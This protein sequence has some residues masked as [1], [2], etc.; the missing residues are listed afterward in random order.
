M[1]TKDEI[2]LGLYQ[3]IDVDALVVAK[4]NGTLLAYYSALAERIVR[5]DPISR[6]E[7]AVAAARNEMFQQVTNTRGQTMEDRVT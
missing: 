5:P 7:E 4:R 3:N 6:R 1:A 2:I